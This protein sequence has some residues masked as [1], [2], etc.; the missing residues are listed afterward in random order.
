MGQ[1]KQVMIA[2]VYLVIQGDGHVVGG[3]GHSLV[4]DRSN[5]YT[6]KIISNITTIIM[7][8]TKS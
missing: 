1:W 5:T 3:R 6:I 2:W 4:G 7:E 8:K